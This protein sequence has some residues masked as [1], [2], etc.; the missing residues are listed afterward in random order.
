MPDWNRYNYTRGNYPKLIRKDKVSINNFILRE[1]ICIVTVIVGS[2]IG[3]SYY[4]YK[5]YILRSKDKEE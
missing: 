1:K 3:I 5:L 4:A 2:A